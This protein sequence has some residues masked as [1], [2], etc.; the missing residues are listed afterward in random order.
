[1]ILVMIISIEDRVSHDLS[2]LGVVRLDLLLY[3][4]LVTLTVL[5]AREGTLEQS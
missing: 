5:Q 4:F 2:A 1:M 3:L